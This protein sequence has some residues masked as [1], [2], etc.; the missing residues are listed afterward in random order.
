MK[1]DLNQSE[2]KVHLW[3]P[4]ESPDARRRQA[5]TVL[6]EWLDDESGY[7]EKVW[8]GVKQGLEENRLSD[9]SRF[10]G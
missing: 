6:T 4:T 3:K 5:V 8:P 2:D 7:D 10:R 9:R 1:P